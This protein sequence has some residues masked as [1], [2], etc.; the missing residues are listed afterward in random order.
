MNKD[1]D[2]LWIK[3]TALIFYQIFSVDYADVKFEDKLLRGGGGNSTLCSTWVQLSDGFVK[4]RISEKAYNLLIAMIK[5]E[6]GKLIYKNG[7]TVNIPY[8]FIYKKYKYLFSSNAKGAEK[9]KKVGQYFHQDHNPSNQKVLTLLKAKIKEIRNNKNYLNELS[10][11][12]KNIQTVDLITVEEDDIRTEAD[13]K[14]SNKL[15]AIERDRL[16]SAKFY[17]LIF[18]K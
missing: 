10:I 3:D 14:L 12:I 4:H 16:I 6:D 13:R 17:D 1:F 5:G 9:R 11:Y 7:N 2:D 8:Y 15:E 18:Y